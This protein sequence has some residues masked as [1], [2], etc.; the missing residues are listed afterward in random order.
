MRGAYSLV[1]IRNLTEHISLNT[2]SPIVKHGGGSILLWECFSSAG[3][4]KLR[5]ES[6]PVSSSSPSHREGRQTELQAKA[7]AT[8]PPA[9][10]QPQ[11]V[12]ARHVMSTGRSLPCAPSAKP[13][14]SKK[15]K[16]VVE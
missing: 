15:N 5:R 14:P 4:G 3:T 6:V 2:P 13:H 8:A 12:N 1:F 16:E 9:G 7:D 11:L 10:S